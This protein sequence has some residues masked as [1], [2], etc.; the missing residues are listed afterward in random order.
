MK[1]IS[2]THVDI[3]LY[4][5]SYLSYYNT[6]NISLTYLVQHL[7]KYPLFSLQGYNK[8]TD[9]KYRQSNASSFVPIMEAQ[10]QH[11]PLGVI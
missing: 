1:L 3:Q 5:N 6:V 7:Y 4:T 2:F 11:K 10:L 9:A 8:K